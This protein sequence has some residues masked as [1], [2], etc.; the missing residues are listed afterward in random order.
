[1]NLRIR[2][3]EAFDN[4]AVA[5][6]LENEAR[7]PLFA[8]SNEDA[9]VPAGPN[10]AGSEATFSVRFENHFAAGRI[11]V[12]PWIAGGPEGILDR[13]PRM[14]SAIV[15]SRKQTGGMVEIP[16]EVS[17]ETSGP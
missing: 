13:R 2:Y 7:Q 4:P 12:S 6:L 9:D 11:Y 3:R 8:T 10:E 15:T 1:V 17:Y 5:I 16:H 14:V